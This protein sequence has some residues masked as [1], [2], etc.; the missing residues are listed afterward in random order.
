MEEATTDYFRANASGCLR[1]IK[2]L[3]MLGPQASQRVIAFLDERIQGSEDPRQFG[4][5]L[6]GDL[7]SSGATESATAAH[8]ASSTTARSSSWS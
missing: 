6:R 5:A 3:R 7:A 4:N 8:Y 1:A 2:Q